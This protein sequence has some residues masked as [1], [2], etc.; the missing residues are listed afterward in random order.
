MRRSGVAVD[1]RANAMLLIE[2]D[3]RHA[4]LDAMVEVLGETLL[5]GGEAVDVVAAQDSAQRARLWEARRG[6]SYAT[7]KMAKYKL[8]ED[9]VVPRSR[10]VPLLEK[11]AEQCARSKVRHLTYG[12]AGDGNMHVSFLWD[13]E[14]ELPAVDDAI[15]HLMTTTV[16]LGGTL[17]GEHGIGLTKASYL[18]LEQSPELIELERSLKRVFDPRGL[19]NPGKIFPTRHTAC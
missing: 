18:A 8:S 4:S 19:L 1:A 10:L 3:G 12:H 14:G 7:R 6:L 11:T 2:V 17:S 5:A 9:V 15:T 16:E 13:D